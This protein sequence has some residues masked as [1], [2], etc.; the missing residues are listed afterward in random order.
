MVSDFPITGTGIGTFYRISPL[1]HDISTKEFRD[2]YENA[3]NY[4]LQFASELGL[5]ALFIFLGILFM[6]FQAGLAYLRRFKES[7]PL[8]KGFLFGLGAY[9]ITCMTGHP[10]LL[11]NQQFLFWFIIHRL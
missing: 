6:T 9:L 11:S 3:H 2:Y 8:V 1:Y 7:A 10:L 4:F 5:P